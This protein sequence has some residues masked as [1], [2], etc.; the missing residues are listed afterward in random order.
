VLCPLVRYLEDCCA[1]HPRDELVRKED[2]IRQMKELYQLRRVLK[3]WI[4][5]K[6]FKNVI[7]FD[8]LACLGPAASVDKAKAVMADCFHLNARAREIVAVKVKEQIVG[9]LRGRKRGSDTKA[10]S[11]DKRPRL[12]PPLTKAAPV[13]AALVRVARRRQAAAEAARASPRAAAKAANRC[14]SMFNS[15]E[16]FF[17]EK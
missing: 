12:D 8:P 13:V 17:A 16:E 4:I 1:G 2:G 9:W 6:K 14:G 3:S 7:M 15:S 5:R 11:E 10:G